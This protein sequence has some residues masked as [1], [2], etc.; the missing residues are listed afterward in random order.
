MNE[1]ITWLFEKPIAHRGVRFDDIPENSLTAFKEAVNAGLVIELDVHCLKDGTI[2]VFHDFDTLRMTGKA[3]MIVHHTLSSVK[4]LR[5]KGDGDEKIP[6]LKEVLDLVAGKTGLL[7][8]LKVMVSYKKLC[9]ELLKLL[10]GYKGKVA[11]QGFSQRAIT[12]IREHS[13]YPVGLIGMNYH[14]VGL[15]GFY[16]YWLNKVAY[17]DRIKPDF[18]NYNINHIPSSTTKRFSGQGIPILGWTIRNQK[19]FDSAREKCGNVIVETKYL[20]KTVISKNYKE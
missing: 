5:L 20:D 17:F 14:K 13:E 16:G 9:V 11:I 3:G 6:T 15:I 10:E 12:Y 19:Q 1:N 2:V 7:I 8:E 4:K 18:L